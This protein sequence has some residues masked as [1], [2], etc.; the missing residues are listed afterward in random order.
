VD[1]A[2]TSAPWSD[3]PDTSEAAVALGIANQLTNILRDVG[4]DRGRGR[5][6]LP[7][8][9]LDRFGYSESDLIKD[10]PLF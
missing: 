1:Q 2:Y 4:E 5:I 10:L 6:Y 8:E 7:Q 9:D 3:S